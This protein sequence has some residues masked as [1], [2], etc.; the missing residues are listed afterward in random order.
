MA[1]RVLIGCSILAHALPSF[2]R[3]ARPVAVP[4]FHVKV[5][6]RVRPAAN[7]VIVNAYAVL[8]RGMDVGMLAE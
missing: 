5:K 3:G 7:T 6:K 8:F 2:A 4:D 1:D